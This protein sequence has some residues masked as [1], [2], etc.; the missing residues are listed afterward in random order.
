M[1][2]SNR[3]LVESFV[4]GAT[5]GRANNMEIREGPIS[6]NGETNVLPGDT[7][8]VAYGWAI[9][10][11]RSSSGLVTVND[12]WRDWANDKDGESG[13]TT[14]QHISRI[15]GAAR[16]PDHTNDKPQSSSPPGSAK[17]MRSPGR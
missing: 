13:Q 11:V 2:Q 8:I 10:A 6:H 15:E 7:A 9:Y 3:D 17:T 12:G 14:L 4:N 1:S 5:H 16:D